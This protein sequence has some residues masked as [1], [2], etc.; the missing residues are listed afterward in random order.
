MAREAFGK[1][2]EGGKK[3][4][5]ERRE[6][7]YHP[8]TQTLTSQEW[9]LRVCVGVGGWGWGWGAREAFGKEAEGEKKDG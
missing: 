2:E 1:E 9:R 3:D 4:G 5:V 7:E 8:P 6:R